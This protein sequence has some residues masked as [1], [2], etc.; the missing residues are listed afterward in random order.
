[1]PYV[2]GQWEA[3]ESLS[4]KGMILP[5]EA[6]YRCPMDLSLRQP[7]P[8]GDGVWNRTSYVMN[9]LLS[10]KTRRYGTWT[11]SRFINEMGSSHFIAFCER[12]ADGIIASGGDPKQDDYDIWLGTLIIKPW[13]ADRRHGASMAN[14]LY[15]DIHVETLRWTDAVRDM[16][17]DKNVLTQDGS[18]PF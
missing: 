16:Y 9:S 17:P 6:I 8:D 15:L 1:M 4:K 13:I 2:G 11:L 5:S 3:D 10:H 18:Y 14:Y 7:A 12:D